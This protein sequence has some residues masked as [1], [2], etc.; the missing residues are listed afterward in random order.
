MSSSIN[1]ATTEQRIADLRAIL[2]LPPDQIRKA[3]GSALRPWENVLASLLG[4]PSPTVEQDFE[5]SRG[6]LPARVVARAAVQAWEVMTPDRRRNMVS[7]T[8]FSST[9]RRRL[10]RQPEPFNSPAENPF[11]PSV[12]NSSVYRAAVIARF[13]T[14]QCDPPSLRSGLDAS[15]LLDSIREDH[16]QAAA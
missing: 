4:D 5:D 2:N 10:P 12:F 8:R 11:T 16:L 3:K 7:L 14:D 6:R 1:T 13:Y 15:R 9:R